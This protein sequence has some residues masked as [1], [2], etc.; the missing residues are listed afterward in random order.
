MGSQGPERVPL[1]SC[2]LFLETRRFPI[3]PSPSYATWN[4]TGPP[5]RVEIQAATFCAVG[6]TVGTEKIVARRHLEVYEL[7]SKSPA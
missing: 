7:E 1:Q 6:Q 5:T 2:G 4:H 3:P